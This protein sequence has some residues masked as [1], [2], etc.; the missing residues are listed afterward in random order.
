VKRKSSKLTCNQ[1]IQIPK[2]A[3]F[4]GVVTR[5]QKDHQERG[6]KRQRGREA[7][8]MKTRARCQSFIRLNREIEGNANTI[9]E[10][11]SPISCRFLHGHSLDET[12]LAS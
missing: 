11:K 5:V 9:N 4:Q 2:G 10:E 12:Q 3:W 8:I 7:E 6:Q 1:I